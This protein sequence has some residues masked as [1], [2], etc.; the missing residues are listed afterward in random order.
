MAATPGK[1][2]AAE[3]LAK[4]YRITSNQICQHASH[5]L[6]EFEAVAVDNTVA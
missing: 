1:P 6:A 4:G 3:T 5:Q 2:P